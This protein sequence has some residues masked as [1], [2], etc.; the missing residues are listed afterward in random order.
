MK[1]M[2]ERRLTMKCNVSAGNCRVCP[3]VWLAGLLL[4]GMLIQNVFFGD[5]DLRPSAK[6]NPA[7]HQAPGEHQERSANVS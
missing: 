1:Q 4:V 6:P 3:G 2:T 5:S 7:P